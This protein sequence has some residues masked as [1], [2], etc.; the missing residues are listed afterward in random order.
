MTLKDPARTNGASEDCSEEE[1]VIRT[2][3]SDSDADS[4]TA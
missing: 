4:R 2:L 3:D 1:L